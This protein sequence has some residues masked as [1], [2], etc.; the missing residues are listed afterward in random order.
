MST[1]IVLVKN[2]SQFSVYF[3]LSLESNLDDL[4]LLD[5][6]ERI[7]LYLSLVLLLILMVGIL[8]SSENERLLVLSLQSD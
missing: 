2:F 5:L 4:F 1:K 7:E 3:S 6:S 8:M